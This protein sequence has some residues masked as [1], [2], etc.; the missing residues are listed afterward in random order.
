MFAKET[1]E[2]ETNDIQ[3]LSGNER[4]YALPFYRSRRKN[5]VLKYLNIGLL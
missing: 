4:I 3:Q 1:V 2:T 5:T